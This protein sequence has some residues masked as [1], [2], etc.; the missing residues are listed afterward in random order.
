MG[1]RDL[2]RLLI[3]GASSVVRWAR[4][5]GV[6]EGSWLAKMIGRKPPMLITVALANRM[7]RIAWALMTKGGQYEAQPAT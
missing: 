5:H 7:A 6:P 1:Q 2:R 3:I 4:R